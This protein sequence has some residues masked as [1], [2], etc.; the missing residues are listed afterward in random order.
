MVVGWEKPLSWL[1]GWSPEFPLWGFGTLGLLPL[2]EIGA[3]YMV[4]LLFKHLVVW[5]CVFFAMTCQKDR[6][7]RACQSKLRTFLP[8]SAL[9]TAHS[10]L[11]LICFY[12]CLCNAIAKCVRT[13]TAKDGGSMRLVCKFPLSNDLSCWCICWSCIVF[14]FYILLPTLEMTLWNR[15]HSHDRFNKQGL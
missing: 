7:C 10:L 5:K 4:F 12:R 13:P 1:G 14:F 3:Y 15:S 2:L 11:S 6:G 9:R 8:S